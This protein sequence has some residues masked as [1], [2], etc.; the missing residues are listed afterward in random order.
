MG[1]GEWC[2]APLSGPSAEAIAVSELFSFGGRRM[3]S[4]FG[5]SRS[6]HESLT[7]FS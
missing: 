4:S 5:T 2:F 1:L 7:T 6:E 3:H